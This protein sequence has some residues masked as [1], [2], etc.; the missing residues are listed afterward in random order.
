M[1]ARYRRVLEGDPAAAFARQRLFELA[2]ERDGGLDGLVAAIAAEPPSY[3][4]RMLLAALAVA[5]G[6]P[7]DARG[8]YQEAGRLRPEAPQPLAALAALA[9]SEGDAQGALTFYREAISR[10]RSDADR[11]E[12]V[13]EL[14]ALAMDAGDFE[15]ARADYAT[16]VPR[17]G[18]SVYLE[19]E[20]AR[21]LTARGEHARAATELERVRARM[22]GDVRALGPLFRDLGRAHR[23]AGDSARA[24]TIVEEGLRVVREGGLCRELYELL[25]DVHRRAG[26]LPELVERLRRASDGVALDVRASVEDELG[27]DAEALAAYRRIVAAN[28]RDVDT[29]VR[30][31]QLLARSGRLDEVADEYRALLRAVPGEPRFVVELA[32]LLVQQGRREEALR[33]AAETS[34]RHP[35]EPRVHRA[36]AELYTRWREGGLAA[37][38]V[39][40]LARL[41]PDDPTHLVA[42]GTQQLEAGDVEGARATWRRILAVE[43]DP[44]RAHATLAG[45]YADHDALVEAAVEYDEALRRD[46]MH[47]ES[48]RGL[49]AV[50]ERLGDS[51]RAAE[52]WERVLAVA[53]E[54]AERREA[55]QR[56]VAAWGRARELP[57]RLLALERAFRAEPPDLDAGRTLAEAWM[58]AS[59]P[60]TTDAERVLE[61]L[62]MLAPGDV[63]SLLALERLRSSRGDLAGA[64]VVLAKLVEADERRASAYLQR[65][66][67]HALALYRDE[68]AIGYARRAA[69]RNPDDAAGHRRLGDLYRA[70]QD[71]ERAVVA[72]RRALELDARLFPTYFDLA[73]LYLAAGRPADADALYRRVVRAS[74]DD[75]LVVRAARASMQIHLGAGTL[76]VLEQELLPLTLA[77]PQR[78]VLRRLV[79]ELYQVL[80][81]PLAQAAQRAGATGEAARSS[82]ARVGTRALKPL[83]EALADPDPAQ[84]TAAV[85][86][87]GAVG[88]PNAAGPLLALAESDAEPGLRARAVVAFGGIV[89]RSPAHAVRLAALAGGSEARL[90]DVATWALART[91]TRADVTLLRTLAG[92]G[93]PAVRA[94]A[95]L[96]FGVA[97]AMESRDLLEALLARDASLDV[98]AAAGW[99]LGRLGRAESIPRLV[100]ALDTG[101]GIVALGAAVALGQ[102]PDVRSRAALA[103][104]LWSSDATMRAIAAAALA[105][106]EVPAILPAPSPPRSLRAYLSQLV[107]SADPHSARPAALGPLVEVLADAARGALAGPLEQVR[108]ALEALSSGP[109]GALGAGALTATLDAWP[110]PARTEARAALADLAGRLLPELR[111]LARHADTGVRALAVLALS[112]V[113]ADDAR[114]AL[115]EALADPAE[116]VQRVALANIAPATGVA[117][118]DAVIRL[119]RTAE[120]WSLRASAARTLGRFVEVERACGALSDALRDD[121]YAFVRE[122]AAVALVDARCVAAEQVSCAAAAGDPEPRVRGAAARACSAWTAP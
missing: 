110:E 51:V 37:A 52:S 31:V 9:R 49:A 2:R 81:P 113:D 46:P 111:R 66:A 55:R 93:D 114:E 103:R 39:A 41:E 63:E 69:E 5:Q 36:L 77:N 68:E 118:L 56:L 79:V 33:L 92:H 8:L 107:Q 86:L 4:T 119:A 34:R 23:D 78:P 61:Q 83:L 45:L 84:K 6:R 97:N 16:L 20:Y 105:G 10:A 120:T 15:G 35:R 11:Q 67:E 89:G 26:R 101:S 62:V 13:R 3:A 109:A 71:V 27:N 19:T 12:W 73:E 43:G 64:L 38:E 121:D 100:S 85:A 88:N 42:L 24:I 117:S 29:R 91:A 28:P 75:E 102:I 99:S 22:R 60:R 48:L 104:A 30:V 76:E 115:V 44:V 25:V 40:L 94:F 95:A 108:G 116:S 65:M 50:R 87:L 58:R 70:R 72:Y 98:K 14:A 53:T 54:R 96:G 80:V 106:A 82:L 74:P 32:Q 17:R 57:R 122:A 7:A 59:P 112:R 18:S 21:A 1:I 90:R 47:L